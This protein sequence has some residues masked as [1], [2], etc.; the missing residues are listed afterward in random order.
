[1]ISAWT[2]KFVHGDCQTALDQASM[3]EL[4]L[5]KTYKAG[6]NYIKTGTGG[7]N[8]NL[9]QS[10]SGSSRIC[11]VSFSQSYGAYEVKDFKVEKMIAY[12]NQLCVYN[13][14][15][16]E[17]SAEGMPYE[18]CGYGRICKNL[19]TNKCFYV[20]DNSFLKICEKEENFERWTF[21]LDNGQEIQ[22]DVCIE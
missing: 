3:I 10:F 1:M 21:Q 20:R 15:T 11:I 18:T 12:D 19:A 5:T 4:D 9:A 2:T 13:P 6:Y 14:L 22:K 8:V 16:E 17:W 7:T